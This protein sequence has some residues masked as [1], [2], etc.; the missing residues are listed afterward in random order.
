MNWGLFW[1]APASS[2]LFWGGA[3]Y[4]VGWGL[5]FGDGARGGAG[6]SFRRSLCG[7]TRI[8]LLFDAH[9]PAEVSREFLPLLASSGRGH[10]NCG[11][12]WPLLALLTVWG[13]RR[14]NVVL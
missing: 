10:L 5:R 3:T 4:A 9:A 6:P 11:L 14:H 7:F 1:L 12:L 8:P 2:G 13:L